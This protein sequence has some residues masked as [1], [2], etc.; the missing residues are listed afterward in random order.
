MHF[1][2]VGSF[3]NVVTTV[4]LPKWHSPTPGFPGIDSEMMTQKWMA[5]LLRLGRPVQSR[6]AGPTQVHLGTVTPAPYMMVCV[7]GSCHLQLWSLLCIREK[8]SP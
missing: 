2:R 1:L 6:A 8:L 3:L 7:R 4:D 5:V